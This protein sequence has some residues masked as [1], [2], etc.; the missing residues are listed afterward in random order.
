MMKRFFKSFFYALAGLR[1][2]VK[3]EQ[4]FR[5]HIAATAAAVAMGLYVDISLAS[6][7]IVILAIGVVLA[8]ELFNTALERLG[9]GFS[10]GAY[11]EFVKREKDLSAA[12]VLVTAIA[13]LAVGVIFLFVPFIQKVF[14]I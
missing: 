10:G 4:S 7:G 5:L 3:S 13:A 14:G 11:N 2:A 9:D 12:A 1:A 6:W 8:A